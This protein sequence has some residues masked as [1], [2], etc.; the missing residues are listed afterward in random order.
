MVGVHAGQIRDRRNRAR[1]LRR[2]GTLVA[3]DGVRSRGSRGVKTC[4]A[5]EADRA[6]AVG[7]AVDL[8]VAA[9]PPGT[10]AVNC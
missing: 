2:I 7:D 4:R 5:D 1:G 3:T 10:V 9:P 6:V 8:Q